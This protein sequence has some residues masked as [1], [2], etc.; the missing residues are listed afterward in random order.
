MMTTYPDLALLG[1]TVALSIGGSLFASGK[2]VGSV[3]SQVKQNKDDIA[4]SLELMNELEENVNRALNNGLKSDISGI[5]SKLSGVQ[6]DLSHC[7]DLGKKVDKVVEDVAYLRG[8]MEGSAKRRKA[9]GGD[10]DED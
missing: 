7:K 9:K 8:Q 10:S 2:Y 5:N 6:S 1:L 4:K 3:S